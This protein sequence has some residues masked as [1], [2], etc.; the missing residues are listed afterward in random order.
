MTV[1]I[2][3]RQ[4][5]ARKL[6]PANAVTDL[7]H[8]EAACTLTA[9]ISADVAMMQTG[10]YI[11][12][13]CVDGKFRLFEA[14]GVNI[15]DDRRM[16]GITATDAAV[17]ELTGTVIEDV[18]Q[19]DVSLGEALKTLLPAWEVRGEAPDRLEKSRAYYATAWTMIKQLETLYAWRIIPYYICEDGMIKTKV[20]ELTSGEAVYR[21]RILQ[22]NKNASKIYVSNTGRPVTRLYGLGPA[23]GAT[24]VQTNMTFADV[25]WSLSK[26]DPADKPKGQTWVADAAV[27]AEMPPYA[28]TVS[29]PDAADAGDLLQQT[30]DALQTMTA[31]SVKA[32]ATVTD[33]EMVPGHGREKIRLGDLVAVKLKSGLTIEAKIIGVKRNYIRPWLTKISIGGKKDTIQTQVA[34]LI[35]SATHTFERLT[36]YQNRFYEDEA[37]IQL[38]AEFI[39]RNATA[40]ED[41]AEEIRLNASQISL[42]ADAIDLLGYVKAEELETEILAVTNRATLERVITNNLSVKNLL[43]VSESATNVAFIRTLTGTDAIITNL[44]VAGVDVATKLTELE[45]RLSDLEG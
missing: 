44:T 40:I 18:Q 36:I 35:A 16:I 26:G 20:L 14:T 23:Q 17:A 38:N 19:L 12:F 1:Y 32:D 11:G 30:W 29:L 37:L 15:N 45:T 6:L 33:M 28:A 13:A 2:F 31:P 34:G 27:E 39:Q 5:R 43:S 3:D 41:N 24:D 10:E 25:E 7:V 22:N 21:G 42:K 4:K 8:D 9:E